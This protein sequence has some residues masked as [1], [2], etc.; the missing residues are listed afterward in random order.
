VVT[1]CGQQR[2]TTVTLLLTALRDHIADTDWKGSEAGP[3]AKRIEAYFLKNV[4]EDGE[5]QQK[6]V[7][8]R[9]DQ[10]T[11]R[12]LLDHA[13]SPPEASERIRDNYDFFRDRLRD[14]DPEAMYRGIGRLVVV[15]VTLER[16]IDDPQLIFE[17]LNSTGLE[18]SQSDLIR[19][20]I[21]MRLP[22]KEQTRLYEAYWSKIEKLFRG[23]ETTFDAFVRDYI[24]L[25]M[26]ASKQERAAD[27]YFA[28]R[29][30]FGSISS[31]PETLE[32]FLQELLRVA[33]NHAAFSI[34]ADAPPALREPLARLRRLV[35]V[36][37]TL[38]MRLFDCL[39]AHR[40]L[41]VEQ[42]V[43]AVGL[44]ESYVFRRAICGEQT[45]GYWQVFATLAYRIAP[46]RPLESLKV[47]LA[48]LADSYGFPGDEG[49]RKALEERDIYHK[50]VC[51][52]LLDRLENHGSKERTDTGKYSIEHIMPQN[53]KLSPEWRRMLG[54]Q[55]QSVQREWL[56][57]LGNLTLTGYNSEY[58][59]RSFDDKK[60]VPGGF[61]ESSVRLNKFVREQPKWTRRRWPSGG[62]TWRVGRP[63]SGLDFS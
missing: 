2:L 3:T 6:L 8:R 12:A 26:H 28:F 5:R 47:G 22:E 15:D 1:H 9:H 57:R 19:N 43:E 4:E 25:R 54:E 21:L 29:R 30:E 59:D 35:D 36:P 11:L 34:G 32:A 14:T 46:E 63:Q 27:I 53:E 50:R 24:A 52:D 60:T 55:W 7:L 13:E 16:G 23:S 40:T 56:H 45:R 31:Q 62:R 48:R 39:E 33:R 49:F 17:S 18:L 44:L 42:F 38:V 61:S 20:F 10:A 51:F 41:D 37:A 58:S